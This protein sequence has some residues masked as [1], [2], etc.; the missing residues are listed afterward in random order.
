MTN[1]DTQAL[2]QNLV[3]SVKLFLNAGEPES[4]NRDGSTRRLHSVEQQHHPIGA[5]GIF[6][7]PR[8]AGAGG[9]GVQSALGDHFRNICG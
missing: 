3:F 1:S 6:L 4:C 9:V 2:C 7:R 5:V 8:I